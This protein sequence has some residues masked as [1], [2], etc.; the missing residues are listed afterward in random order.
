MI[1]NNTEIKPIKSFINYALT[2]DTL[3]L[4][5]FIK[6]IISFLS[7]G[8]TLYR[9]NK[10]INSLP[11]KMWKNVIIFFFIKNGFFSNY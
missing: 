11:V 2:K 8:M 6:S 9:F 7:Y 10:G 3:K 4:Y 5:F 1:K